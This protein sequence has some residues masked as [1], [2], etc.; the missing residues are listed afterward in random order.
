MRPDNRRLKVVLGPL[1]VMLAFAVVQITT[2]SG[3][4]A[5][6]IGKNNAG[7]VIGNAFTFEQVRWTS[8]CD[9]MG[10][11]YGQLKDVAVGNGHCA[12]VQVDL[13]FLNVHDFWSCSD[14]IWSNYLF[15]DGDH[16]SNFRLCESKTGGG[17]QNCSGWISNRGF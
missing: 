4:G 2:S 17:V 8:T 3:A 15:N 5:Y 1:V 10:D 12:I 14:N 16:S 9:D 6:C 7:P 13:G 11:Y